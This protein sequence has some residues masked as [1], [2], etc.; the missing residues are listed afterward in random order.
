MMTIMR[1]LPG[2]GKST[3]ARQLTGDNTVICSADDH[4][5]SIDTGNYEFRP[6]QIGVAHQE[7]KDKARQALMDG[8]DVIIDNTNTQKWEMQPYLDM[9]AFFKVTLEIVNIFDGGCSDEELVER[10]VHNIRLE[11]VKGMR[12]R[13]E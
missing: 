3:K 7:C 4:F 10:C 2:S 6:D 11:T 13:W 12:A 9:A 8:K 1:G 5:I